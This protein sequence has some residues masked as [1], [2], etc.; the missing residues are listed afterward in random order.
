V[1]ELEALLAKIRPADEAARTAALAAWDRKTK[2]RGSLGRIEELGARIAAVRGAIPAALEPAVVVAAAD[3]GVAAEGVSAYPQEVTGQMLANFAAGGAAINVLARAAG[4]RLV[5]VDA[6]VVT[7]FEHPLV[8]SLRLGPGTASLA[9]GPAMSAAQATEGL[10]AGAELAVELARDGIGIVALGEMGI[11]NTTAAGAVTAGLL[12]L[13]P[14]EVCGRG[15]GLDDEGVARKVDAVRRGLASNPGRGPLEMLAGVGGFELAVLAGVALGCAVERIPVLLDGFI[16]G[17]AA[18][19]AARL[20]FASADAMIAAHRSS[21]PGHR[22]VL[23]AL[24]L[25]PL[26]ELDLRLGEGSGAALALP[27]VASALAL[28]RDMATFESAGVSDAGR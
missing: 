11:G 1:A 5:V 25:E 6:G 21:E 17:A 18:L 26:L 27:L 12:G 23:D 15:T 13:D 28:L 7:P 2:P 22:H 16:T 14:T 20:A 19:V 24:G 9:R 3:H 8:R 4:A 10:L